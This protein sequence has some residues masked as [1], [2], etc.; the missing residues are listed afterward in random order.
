M[1][2][3]WKIAHERADAFEIAYA[4]EKSLRET[5]EERVERL[6]DFLREA[7]IF[8]PR[9]HEENERNERS[10]KEEEERRKNLQEEELRRMLRSEIQKKP[11]TEPPPN[12]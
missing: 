7:G 6:L 5:V 12:C 11:P 8:H 3:L 1:F 4:E 9:G 2:E 10:A